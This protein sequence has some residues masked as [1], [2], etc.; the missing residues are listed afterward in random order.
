MAV[1]TSKLPN[2]ENERISVLETQVEG[3][4]TGM[5]KLEQK[6]DVNYNTLHQRI[7]SLRDDLSEEIDD[8]HLRVCDKIEDLAKESTEQHQML[9]EKFTTIEKWKYTIVGG[10]LVLGYF[11]AQFNLANFF[12]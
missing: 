12:Q 9:M 10:A 5:D 3:I 11:A 1:R 7:S 4:H 2:L 6:L 8:K